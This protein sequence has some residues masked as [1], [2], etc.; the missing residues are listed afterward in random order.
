MDAFAEARDLLPSSLRALLDPGAAAVTEEIRL[1][2]SRPMSLL[3]RGSEQPVAGETVSSRHIM[4]VLDKATGASLH[5][6]AESMA[7]GFICYRGL[8]IGLCGEAAVSSGRVMGFRSYASLAIRIPSQRRGVCDRVAAQVF[9]E[10][11]CGV[12]VVSP[13]G[14]GK[15]TA[16]RELARVLG[17]RG[18]RTAVADERNELS[19]TVNG[20]A[21]FEL[22]RCSDVLVGVPKAEAAMMLLRGM[23]P[24]II[25]MDEI[26]QDRDLEAI[27]ELSGCG[28]AVLA[29]AHGKSLADMLSRP[30]Y[31]ELMALRAFQWLVTISQSGGARHYDTERIAGT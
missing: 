27:R 23:N 30:L 26:T 1:R 16:L 5:S 3:Q 31:R 13:P 9:R 28:V 20:E 14:G 21:G 11:P 12:L 18:L 10:G 17:D 19:A 15:T 6:A 22:G 29:S 4:Q 8:R 2:R 7:Q 25:A 24:Q